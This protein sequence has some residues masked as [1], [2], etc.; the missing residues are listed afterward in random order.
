MVL[1]SY[2]V[3]AAKEVMTTDNLDNC[4]DV[5]K[6]LVKKFVALSLP[7]DEPSSVLLPTDSVYEYA[8]DF[9]TIG[10]LWHGFHDSIRHGDGNRIV[11]YWKFLTVLFKE[12]G[13]FNYAK[14]GFS[15]VAQSLLFS[16]R[17]AAELKWCRTVNT[18]GRVGQNVPVDLH[19]EHLNA[20][21]KSMLHHLGSNIM[22]DSVLHASK[23]L[24]AVRTVCTNFEDVTDITLDTGFHARPS[25]EKDLMKLS[26]ELGSAEVFKQKGNRQYQGFKNHKPRMSSVDWK[27]V[28]NWVKEQIINYD[29]TY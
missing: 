22:P 16:P 7:S 4:N 21:L 24:G 14:E 12:E 23:A 10:L 6:A 29:H 8:I 2:I 3:S 13:H 18:H 17:K 28:S 26:D 9:L 1:S 20:N 19:M 5:A 15:L 27:K 25:F 11:T